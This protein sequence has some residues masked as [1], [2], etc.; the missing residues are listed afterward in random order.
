M[1]QDE[2]PP[3]RA[4]TE[5]HVLI[6]GGTA[7][8]GLATAIQFALAGS[9]GIALVGRNAERGRQACA[10]V[11]AHA[12]AARV[13]FIAGDANDP[14]QAMQAADKAR[15]HLGRIDVLV[16]STVAAIVPRLLHDTPVEDIAPMLLG[17]ML[18]PL[19]MSRIVLPWMREQR[20]GLIVNIA[21]DAGKLAT[22]GES[23]IGAAMAGIVMFSRTL[24]MEAKRD[25]IRINTLTPSLIEGTL[26][27]DRVTRDGFSAKLFE[28]AARM[29][30]L[31]LTQ[32]E[33]L[34]HLILF[35]A[36]P[37]AVR[38]TGQTISPNGGISAA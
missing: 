9:P 33:D 24:A 8:V 16:N 29:A 11:H 34:A 20:S 5:S 35:L 1:P 22:P 6:V 19:L 30:S 17:Q 27:Y 31:G 12:P 38:I 23:V 25:G 21:S 3:A 4:L 2:R 13:E 18:A 36:R 26:T 15:Q 28:K 10:E 14:A 7:G 32:P 37:E